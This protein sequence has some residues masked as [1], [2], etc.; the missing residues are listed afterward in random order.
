MLKSLHEFSHS[1]KTP[2]LLLFLEDTNTQVHEDFSDTVELKALIL[3]DTL[4]RPIAASIGHALGDWLRSFHTW[5]STQKL[6]TNEPM[7]K[8]KHLVTYESFI[9]VLERFPNVLQDN[10]TTLEEVKDMATKELLH[11]TEDWATIH[12]DFWSGK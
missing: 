6:P 7:Q 12:A 4:S 3:S 2:K 9:E 8:L 10:K 5:S 11:P 1:V